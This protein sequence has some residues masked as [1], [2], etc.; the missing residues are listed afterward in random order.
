MTY[1]QIKGGW[2]L[3]VIILNDPSLLS[4]FFIDPMGGPNFDY[5]LRIDEISPEPQIGWA[6]D[7]ENFTNPNNV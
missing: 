5:V 4:L 6:Y 3:N 1:A 2:I 7:G